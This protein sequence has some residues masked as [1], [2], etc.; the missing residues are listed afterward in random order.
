MPQAGVGTAVKFTTMVDVLRERAQQSPERL[1]YV[2]LRDGERE[3]TRLT[4]GAVDRRAR[5][6][7]AVLQR[8][9]ARGERA[10]LLFP[11]SPDFVTAFFG[12]LYAGVIAVPAPAPGPGRITRD[13]PRLLAMVQDARPRLVLTTSRIA[14]LSTALAAAAPELGTPRW[15]ATDTLPLDDADGWRD[16]NVDDAAIAYLQYTSGSTATPKGVVVTHANVVH[17]A[18]SIQSH[19]GGTDESLAVSWL[20]LYHDMGLVGAVLA[21][22]HSRARSVLMSPEACLQRPLRWLSAI[23]KYRADISGGPNFAFEH[24]LRRIP[25]DERRSLDLSSWRVAFT[26]AEPIRAATLAPFADAF[27][28]HGFRRDAFHPCYGLAESTLLV[29]AGARLS[30]PVI[31]SWLADA[32]AS[33]RAREASPDADPASVRVLVGCG[34]S[35][36]DQRITIV[37]PETLGERGAREI[38][39]IWVSSPS[40]AH[41]YWNQ[42]E[43]TER[44]FRA[45]LPG[46]DDTDFLRTGDLGFLDEGEL[47]V[48]GRLKDLIIID[49]RNHYPQ[50]VEQTAEAADPGIRPGSC[51]AFAIDAGTEDR[52]II[53]AETQRASD[54]GGADGVSLAIRRAVADVHGVEVHAV[55]LLK[56][57]GVPRTSSGKLRRLACRDAYLTG[58]LDAVGDGEHVRHS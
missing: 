22:L 21:P 40:V 51:A 26:G 27:A 17:N 30:P 35:S 53:V 41:G 54:P 34:Q 24:C 6:I 32:L 38:G 37:D 16:P 52:L 11:T 20:P 23:S 29:T 56:P 15:M 9:R 25:I 42:P 10:L 3:D 44:A 14:R 1:S 8:L 19:F 57:G 55:R 43:E 46:G 49:G 39:E 45:R 50:D 33:G 12:C 18:A 48:T 13:L 7:A 58:T 2:F 36:S 31:R 5:A 4:S 28:A 47:F